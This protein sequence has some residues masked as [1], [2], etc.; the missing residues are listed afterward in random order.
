M[1]PGAS[2]DRA[3]AKSWRSA[4]AHIRSLESTEAGYADGATRLV[5]TD[6]VQAAAGA[7]LADPAV[8]NNLPTLPMQWC[9][10]EL[11]RL[12]VYQNYI[13][14]EYIQYLDSLLPQNPSTMDIFRFVV[15]QTTPA[16]PMTFTRTSESSVMFSSI[17]SDMRHIENVAV[18]YDSIK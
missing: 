13:D 18:P 8:A 14:L 11:D 5:L 4:K 10:V 2:I 16:P 1:G 3:L 12:V 6:D 9:L 7:I 17:S 15:G